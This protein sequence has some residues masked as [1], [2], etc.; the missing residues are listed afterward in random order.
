MTANMG[1]ET[2]EQLARR[3]VSSPEGQTEL[4]SGAEGNQGADP[5][6][7]GSLIREASIG[8]R[9]NG[10][11]RQS[12]MQTMQSN[13]G[14]RAV[15]R[16]IGSGGT[17]VQRF[18]EPTPWMNRSPFVEPTP[19]AGHG[20]RHSGGA[21][22]PSGPNIGIEPYNPG[23]GWMQSPHNPLVTGYDPAFDPSY[24]P[25]LGPNLG[26]GPGAGWQQSPRGPLV[27]G[28]DPGFDPGFNPGGPLIGPNLGG[29]GIG[30][31]GYDPGF[32][33]GFNPGGPLLGPNLG[34]EPGVSPGGGWAQA[35][36]VPTGR[37]SDPGGFNPFFNPTFDFPSG[38]AMGWEPPKKGEMPGP[39]A[40]FKDN[41]KKGYDRGLEGGF[42]AFHGEADILGIPVVDDFL[43]G[44]GKLGGWDNGQGGMRHGISGN[45]GVG[46]LQFNN[47]GKVSGD[48]EALTA[49]A[50]ASWGDD[51][52]TLG[53][54]AT[55]VAGSMTLGNES[56]ASDTDTSARV[57]LSAGM[58]LAG[59]LHWG[60]AD[61]DG[62]AM[63]GF[64][65]DAGPFS[66]DL[67]SE[68]PLGTLAR[69]AAG[70]TT[71]WLFGNGNLTKKAGTAWDSAKQYGS[72]LYNTVGSGVTSAYDTAS[73]GVNSAVD[74]LTNW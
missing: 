71:D 48:A 60:D 30:V 3:R 26:G 36:H 38:S 1:V 67:K 2:S 16:S 11:V 31:G 24:S 27:T 19:W 68:D 74:W 32:N 22:L 63:Y 13:Y 65:V 43:Y 69:V 59:R 70:N 42:G 47:G 6:F 52:A 29:G 45:A 57:G 73:S 50:E 12:A 8:G 33:P 62:N 10:S 7:A 28:Y 64:G 17:T 55:A 23:T 61:K 41:G 58:G 25:S 35:P 5:H 20:G 4:E 39:W 49:S 51:G 34:V 44:M 54:Q 56:A 9:G 66:V 40:Y 72:D 15:Q 21:G 18:T 53:A 46:K 37:G 14:N